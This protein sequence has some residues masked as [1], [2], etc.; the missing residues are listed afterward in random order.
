VA[1]TFWPGV[2]MYDTVAQYTQVLGGEVD[3]WHPPIMVR[4]WQLLHHL[5]GTTEPM[6]ALQ[7]ALYACGFAL[8]VAALVY[9][10]RWRAAVA[11]TVLTLSPLLLG[12]Q[13]VVLKDAQMLGALLAAFGIVTHFRLSG[14]PVPAPAAGCVALLIG[15]AT[16]VRVNAVFA[17]IPLVVLLLPRPRSMAHRGLIGLVAIL[18]ILGV[19]PFINH[20]VFSAEPSGVAKSQP[21]FDLA[22]IAVA[23][24]DP[25]PFTWPERDRMVARHCVKNFFWDSLADPR[26]CGPVTERIKGEGEE[27][28]YVQLALS[29]AAHPIAYGL[30]RARHWNSTERWLVPRNLPGAAPP[31]EAEPNNA[32]LVTPASVFAAT[33]QDV[34]AVEAGFPIGWPVIWTTLALLLLLPA[35]RG[36]GDPAGVLA[37]ALVVSALSLE[38][39]FVAISIASDLRYHL[40]PMTAS[41][42]ALI[43]LS[44]DLRLR[45]GERRFG[46]TAM[47]LV[48]LGGIYSRAS[49][50]PAPDSYQGMLSAA[51]G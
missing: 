42:L 45:R 8:I 4:L 27:Q 9:V 23:T 44:D 17:A 51:S 48:A 49:L 33:W 24:D 20:R 32:G 28:L 47:L 10:G 34:A 37:L 36:R 31:I 26:M 2:A 50:P 39:S 30:H 40:W 14:R 22:A 38:A 1:A 13:M 16:L 46:I 25:A 6:F 3:D 35:W 5:G 43:L 7:V 11:A 15:Y 21:L 18:V 19:S 29:A 41:A 12:W